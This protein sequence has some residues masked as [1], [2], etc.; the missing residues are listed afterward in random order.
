[1]RTSGTATVL[2]TDLVGSTDLMTRLGDDA[3]DRLRGEH[4]A[5]LR[6]AVT[7]CGGEEIKNTGDGILATFTSA[8]DALAAAVAVQQATDRQARSA[9][10]P[11]SIRVG[12]SIGEVGF[13]EGDVFGTPVVEAARLVA[14]AR[15]GQILATAV[16]RMLAGSRAGVGFT[17]L[18]PLTLKG[19]PEAVA[20]CEVDWEPLAEAI[21]LPALLTGGGRIFVGRDDQFGLLQD[22][23]KEAVAGERRMALIAGE[24]GIGKT[25]LAAQLADELHGE[26]A[27]VLAGRCDEDLGVP[28]Q[29]FVEALRHYTVHASELRLGRFG[30]ELARLAPEL[31]ETVPGL[32]PPLRSDPETERYR[33]FDAVAAWLADA[34]LGSPLLLVLDDLHWAAKPTLLLL[35]HILRSAEPLPL[36]IVATYRD[37]EVGR[38]HPLND[39]LADLRRLQGIERIHLTGLDQAAVQ[40]FVEAA[41]G[42]PL[43]EEDASFSRTVWAETEGHP[44]FVAEVL[45]HLAESGAVAQDDAGR[46]YMTIE[47]GEL[48]I[49]EGV[50][51]VVG[52]RLSRLSDTANRALAVASVVGLVFSADVVLGAGDLAEDTL[53]S[54]LEEADAANLLVEIAGPAPQ[55][56]FSHALVRATLYDELTAARRVALHRRVGEAIETLHV[57]AL[58]DHLPALA[59]HWSRASAPVADAVKAVDYSARAG[60]RALAQLANDEAVAYYGQAI[61]LLDVAGGPTDDARRLELLISLGEAQRRSGDAAHRE[62]LLEAVRLAGE[63][64]D[65]EAMAR[66]ALANNRG[67]FSVLGN[68]DR[69]RVDALEAALAAVGHTEPSLRARLLGNLALELIWSGDE[70]RRRSLTDEA[71]RLARAHGDTAVQAA[72]IMTRWATSWNPSQA[73]E[74][75]ELATEL[76][77]IAERTA[78]P[79]V[80]FWGWWRRTLALMELGELDEARAAHRQASEQAD[81]LGQPFARSCAG[82]SGVVDALASGHLV[83][84]ERM[85][86][87]ILA[88]V[89]DSGQPDSGAYDVALIA[90]LRYEQGRLG[91]MEAELRERTEQLPAVPFFRALLALSQCQ[92]GRLDDARATFAPLRE[93]P[94]RQ[95]FDYY[96]APTAALLAMVASE[97]DDADAAGRIAAIIAPYADQVAS[98]PMA[99]FGCYHHHMGLLATTLG[100]FSDAEP[101]FLEAAGTHKRLGSPTWLTRTRLECARMLLRRNGPG[102]A[103]R[104]RDMLLTAL[105][106]AREL[107]MGE[108]ERRAVALLG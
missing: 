89:R 92:L 30:G 71:L 42:H 29:P 85:A 47:G 31:A 97:L 25:R 98:H 88:V 93:D 40:A 32:A 56:R 17:N 41:A 106:D 23:W 74:R 64:G 100:R 13:E 26:G 48:G 9:D 24:P 15:P 83:E 78:D 34:S 43:A 96:A 44:F 75:L 6:E 80:R 12:M 108:I 104:A 95:I 102:D 33:L 28:Y 72:L 1:M 53:Y 39:L 76:L 58:D 22:R 4:F 38:G 65:A 49:P 86:R 16:V 77:G 37:S 7:G 62:T 45:R 60:D 46:W 27:L 99:W 20:V 66:A 3:F 84:A 87:E 19:L 105:G 5:R 2:F 14:A 57:E 94:G 107:G 21:P 50:R 18:E 51:D 55:Y 8:V 79:H 69:E 63:L 90:A 91:E 11:V 101:L 10:V 52:Q 36:F 54:A 68:V 73:W 103:P 81:D 61:E 70:G 59:H 82:L 67:T 35:R